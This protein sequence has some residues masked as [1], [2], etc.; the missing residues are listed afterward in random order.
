MSEMKDF[1][2]K[3]LQWHS[4]YGRRGLPW[5]NEK[6]PYKVWISEIMLQQT[7]VA[8]VK[9]RYLQ[10]VQ[11]FPSVKDLARATAD[12]VMGLWA[13]LGYYTRARNLHAC[14]KVIEQTYQGNFPNEANT[15]STLPGIGKSTAS[16]IA[17]FCFNQKISILDANVKRL[18]GRIYAVKDDLK[19]TV[20][21]EYLWKIA[22]DLLPKTSSDMPTY[23]QALMD[24]GATVCTPRSPNCQ[25][26]VFKKG[27]LAYEQGI[28]DQIP[29][30]I[31]KASIKEV[32]S[33]MLCILAKDQL[34]L[35]L[36]PPSGIWGGLWCLP[37]SRWTENVDLKD[38]KETLKDFQ[39]LPLDILHKALPKAK[40]MAPRKHVFTHR[41]LYFQI[42]ILKL[43][44]PF[45]IDRNHFKWV[46]K[47]E[48]QELGLP[49]PVKQFIQDYWSINSS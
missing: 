29:K 14:A 5:Q 28:V 35:H 25:G 31:K 17:A 2:T 44:Q 15:L 41:I 20:T 10:F 26:C 42:G 30:K 49:T 43:H 16:A 21:H 8:T 37:E 13:G 12:E 9:E 34:L 1:S 3:L 48:V 45:E 19:K 47:I 18:L 46:N 11:T 40:F 32:Q 22:Q 7:Q 39:D 27:C 23:T 24:Y 36:R 6:D 4:V 38:F 33:V